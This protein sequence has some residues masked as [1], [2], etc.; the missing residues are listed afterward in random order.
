MAGSDELPGAA[1]LAARAA[2]RTGAG[3]VRLGSVGAVKEAAAAAAPELL[4]RVI[5]DESFGESSVERFKDA[6]EEASAVAVGPGIGTGTGQRAFIEGLLTS[7]SG[8]VALDA[9][10][11]NVLASDPTPLI[12]RAKVGTVVITPHPGE[13]GRLLARSS[14]EI[15]ADRLGAVTEAR[16]RFGCTVLLKGRR[17]LIAAPRSPVLINPTGGPELA[18]GGSGDVL[19]GIIGTLLATGLEGR[20]AAA[21]AAYVHGI[22]GSIARAKA[23]V[24]SG[25]VATDVLEAIPE[26]M[27]LITA[28]P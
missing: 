24:P 23:G 28:L 9:D 19:T 13:L 27:A 8:P 5:A 26:A 18:S 17:T 15:Q 21:A 16:D 11:L 22:A 12:E 20:E 4:V 7:F 25:V 1:L 2:L 3:Y 10:A 14:K 6:L